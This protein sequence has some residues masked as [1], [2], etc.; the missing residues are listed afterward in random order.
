MIDDQYA[1]ILRRLEALEYHF[2]AI[3]SGE[4]S[5]GTPHAHYAQVLSA[6]PSDTNWH[7]I[8]LSGEVPTETKAVFIQA[9]IRDTAGAHRDLIVSNASSGNY[10]LIASTSGDTNYD[11]NSGLIPVDSSLQIWWRVS[12][13][14]VDNAIIRITAYY[15]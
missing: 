10:Y 13:A 12:S 15:L 1:K 6:D 2:R 14:D 11:E 7:A 3:V 5:L 9:I 8:N 4:P